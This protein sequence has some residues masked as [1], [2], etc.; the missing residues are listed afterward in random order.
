MLIQSHITGSDTWC[1]YS[2]SC[3]SLLAA[4]SML[5][6]DIVTDNEIFVFGVMVRSRNKIKLQGGC[7]KLG[8]RMS[9]FLCVVVLDKGGN[10][11]LNL[12]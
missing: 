9:S 8:R 10:L 12:I 4:G 11:N 6:K 3:E 5:I 2:H 7:T 1:M